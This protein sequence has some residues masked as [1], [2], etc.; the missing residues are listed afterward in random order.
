MV[1]RDKETLQTMVQCKTDLEISSWV[2]PDA[3]S[4]LPGGGETRGVWATEEENIFLWCW[5]L[6]ACDVQLLQWS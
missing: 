4:I 2:I 6:T 5:V 3:T 1:Q